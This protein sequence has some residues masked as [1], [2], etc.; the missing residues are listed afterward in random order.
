MFNKK[1]TM[2]THAN[3]NNM[4]T[5][6][7][8]QKGTLV[9]YRFSDYS[10]ID[11]GLDMTD[12]EWHYGIISETHWYINMSDMFGR[13]ALNIYEVPHEECVCYD[14]SVHNMSLAVKEM[15]NIDLYEIQVLIP[16]ES[17]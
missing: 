11:Y 1:F 13:H 7:H 2:L 10:I 9:R 15:I 17:E 14:L 8:L 6:N 16:K 4:Y 5:C 3:V 12:N